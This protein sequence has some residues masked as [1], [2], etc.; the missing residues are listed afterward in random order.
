M[1]GGTAGPPARATTLSAS[2][3][4]TGS[5]VRGTAIRLLRIG[6]GGSAS[7]EPLAEGTIVALAS[8]H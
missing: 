6:P 8:G 5:L 7:S 4:Q 3:R 2:G 1:H